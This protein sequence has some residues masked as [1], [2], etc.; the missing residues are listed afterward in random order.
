LEDYQLV[1]IPP[2]GRYAEET[3]KI[4]IEHRVT[5]Y[6]AS[7]VAVGKVRGIGIFTADEKL[8]ERIKRMRS[9]NTSEITRPLPA[10]H[11][12]MLPLS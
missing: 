7:Y 1:E 6:E 9:S 11:E 8:L 5:I 10:C 4:S 12:H 3:I 2:D